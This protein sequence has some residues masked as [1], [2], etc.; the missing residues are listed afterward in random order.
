MRLLEIYNLNIMLLSPS[1]LFL[2]ISVNLGTF[3]G[4]KLY[5]YIYI[6]KPLFTKLEELNTEELYYKLI[7]IEDL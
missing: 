5:S 3:T 1:L 4:K 7:D 2:P 6:S